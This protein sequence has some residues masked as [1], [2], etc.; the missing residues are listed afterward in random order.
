M[1]PNVRQDTPGLCP[2]CG[3]NLIKSKT[4][5]AGRNAAREAYDKHAGHSVVSFA[6][7][8]LVSLMLTVPVVLYSELPEKFFGWM[9]P[10]FPGSQYISLLLG[11][12]VFFYG[13]WVF[14]AGAVREL[15]AK[16]PGMMTLIALAISAAYLYSV[17]AALRG[18]GHTLF[19]ELTTL[20]AIMLLGHWMEMK[21]V[22]GA[23]GALKE[24]S[25]LLPD[26]AEVIREG[27]TITIPLGE[28]REGDAVFVRP[29]GK[30]PADGAVLEG[31]SD[32]SEAMITGESKPVAKAPSSKVIAGTSNGDG[33]LKIKVT[34][35]GAHTFLA[36]VMRLVAEAQASK[37]R[38]Q[39][40]SDRAA[41]YLTLLAVASG[42]ATFVVWMFARGDA[43]FAIERLV[44][45]LVI[46]CPHAL[47]L[48]VPLVASIS[49]TLAARSGLLVRQRLA[50]EAARKIDVV[51]FDKTGTLTKGDYGIEKIWA[52]G[53]A[54]DS[55]VLRLAASVD[56]P[57]EHFISRALVARAREEHI[58]LADVQG[59]RRIP[60]KGVRGEVDGKEILVGGYPILE[61]VRTAISGELAGEIASENKKG[62][63]IIFAVQHKEVIGAFALADR[64]REESREAV[65]ALRQM[66]LKVAML[67]GDSEDVAQWVAEELGID[68]YFARVLPQEKSAKVKILQEKGMTVAMVGDGINDAPALVQSDLGIAIG[69][70]TNVAIESAGIILV[71]NDP[72][73]IVRIIKLSRLTYAKMIQNLFWATGYNIVAL[74]LAAGVLA[75]Q[76]ILL[77]PA[78]AALFMSL[79]T[80]IVAL[81]A[82]LLGR[83]A[84]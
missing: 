15:R 49:T 37:S 11:S 60:G 59:F 35:V 34:S 32:V 7:K 50:L 70:G 12:V 55:E 13:G 30:I 81:N 23:Q 53:S 18:E 9:A 63:T 33:A 20:I 38:L 44:A 83:K 29:G 19:W 69:A 17:F 58:Q 52:M 73:D 24:L 46:A 28:L 48:A 40:L 77:Q 36:G 76:G 8:F 51:L 47:G 80:V 1:H 10:V 67:T 71:R 42:T 22:Q 39:L 16:L 43:V 21:A 65:R 25:K 62:K 54:E 72:R 14:I 75:G 4:Q 57:S 6:R 31:T 26:T 3:M 84:I 45:V 74:P 82:L 41:Y 68:E 64:I 61:H 78:L 56:A 79:S 2:E 5:G 27:K 66:G